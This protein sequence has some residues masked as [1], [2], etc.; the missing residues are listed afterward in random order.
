MD[1]L[2]LLW[3]VRLYGGNKFSTL[4]ASSF[5]LKKR[6]KLFIQ[7]LKICCKSAEKKKH[8]SG[9][10]CSRQ[11]C[12][13]PQAAGSN[14]LPTAQCKRPTHPVGIGAAWRVGGAQLYKRFAPSEGAKG[15]MWASLP[16]TTL[17]PL[18]IWPRHFRANLV[19]VQSNPTKGATIFRQLSR[20]NDETGRCENEA[21]GLMSRLRVM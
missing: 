18:M 21:G 6:L 5:L 3:H 1:T 20:R 19:K 7:I 17:A 2:Q 16:L 8:L 4:N 14:F 13:T 15:H 9:R 11:T 12:N 10:Y